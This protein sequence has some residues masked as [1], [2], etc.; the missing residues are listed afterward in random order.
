MSAEISRDQ[1]SA[2]L[3][4]TTRTGFE[5]CPSSNLDDGLQVRGL[6]VGFAVGAPAP[7]KIVYHQASILIVRYWVRSKVSNSSYASQ[8]SNE[9]SGE[10]FGAAGG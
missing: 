10:Q 9:T 8:Y 5:Y 2:V 6:D 1:P 3:K 4:L 7:A